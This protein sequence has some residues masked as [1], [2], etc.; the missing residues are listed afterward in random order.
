ML[1]R[2]RR[3][4]YSR[5]SGASPNAH[6]LIGEMPAPHQLHGPGWEGTGLSIVAHG[7]LFG[8]LAYAA[9]HVS[10]VAK[11]AEDVKVRLEVF[12]DRPGRAGRSGGGPDTPAPP[13]RPQFTQTK[14]I[15]ITPVANPLDTPVPNHVPVM[16]M[17]VQPTLPGAFTQFDTAAPGTGAGPGVGGGRGPGNGPGGDSG[18][19]VG[20]PGGD[21]YGIGNGVTSPVLTREVKPSYTVEAMRAKL[22]GFVELEAVVRPD[23]SV[24]P[25]TVRITR[26]LD[27]VFGLDHQAIVAVRQWKFRPGTLRGQPVAVRVTVELTYSL[28]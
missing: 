6:L 24:D 22:Q 18:P 21:V 4:T 23:G 7:I 16:A 11:T 2:L 9:T 19:G 5:L 26:S 8:I 28:R 14:A 25:A 27:A 12:L 17:E 10:Q 1:R 15:A 20:G 3:M 13:R